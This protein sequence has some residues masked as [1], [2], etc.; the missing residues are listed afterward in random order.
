MKIFK[1]SYRM[2]I[3]EYDDFRLYLKDRYQEKCANDPTYSYRKFAVEAT[4]TNPGF[5]NDII[6]GRRKLSNEA[7]EKMIKVFHL[8]EIEA[9]FF[10]L[11][12]AYRQTKDEERQQELYRRILFRRHHNLA[13]LFLSQV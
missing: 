7:I 1:G 10:R 5:L 13:Q 4:F 9:E 6:K 3:Y 12:V 8:S 11:L 2:N